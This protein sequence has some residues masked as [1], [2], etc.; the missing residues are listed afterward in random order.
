MS[1][2]AMILAGGK[3]ER[4]HPLTIHRAKPAVP[5]A[6]IYRIIDFTLSNCINSGIRKIAVLPQYKSLSLDKHLRLAW[7][8][9]SGE[10]NEFIISVPPQQR[11][12]DKWYQGTADAI[13]QNIYMIEKDAPDYLMV[14]AGDHIYKMDYSEMFR[15]HEEKNADATVAAIEVPRAMAT[16]FGVVEV[17]RNHR[18][19]GFEEKPR[20]PKPI[21]GRPDTA[22]A[23]MG[24]Y[25]FNTKKA[26]K[27]LEFD[28]L[29]DT[30][31]DFGKNIIPQMMKTDLVYAYNFED[32]N[33]KA[34]KYWRDVGTID[35]YWEANMDLVSV[36]PQLNL[37]DRAWPI[38]TYQSQ[39]PPAK[40]VFAQEEKG[41]RLGTALDSIVAHGSIISG[42]RIQN[43]VLSPNVRVNSYSEVYESILMENVQIGRHSRIRKAIIDKDVVIP[44]G[45]EIGYNLEQDRRR[46]HVTSSG[47]VV[48]AKGTEVSE[49]E[50]TAAMVAER[51]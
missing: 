14:L 19:I 46:Y 38:R 50:R 21:P 20:N 24:I 15:F 35:A 32:E 10:L 2:L 39:N 51:R 1:I 9:F 48:I 8:F 29:R 31:H 6:G 34:A 4:L 3:G 23:S 44:P 30:A 22:F 16:S 36:D 7:N 11:V 13:Y 49:A 26:I 17:D 41:G 12:G 45:T 43:S 18:I 47:I 33:K 37:Y 42:G 28:A 27:H 40:F 5:F 25:L